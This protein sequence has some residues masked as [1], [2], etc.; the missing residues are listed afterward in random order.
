MSRTCEILLDGNWIEISPSDIQK[1][2]ILRFSGH[3]E[4]ELPKDEMLAKR[5]KRK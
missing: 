2:D 1:G 4:D 5:I 3:N